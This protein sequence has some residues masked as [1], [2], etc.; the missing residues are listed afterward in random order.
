MI[1][2]CA[3]MPRC[4]RLLCATLR[5]ILGTDACVQVVAHDF[6]HSVVDRL[7]ALGGAFDQLAKVWPVN[8]ARLRQPLVA[9]VVFVVVDCRV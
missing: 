2:N 6:P 4:E 1:A 3:A 8:V 7:E 9:I 5:L